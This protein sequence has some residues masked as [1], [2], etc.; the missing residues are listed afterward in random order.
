MTLRV[1]RRDCP[2]V[3]RSTAR[4]ERGGQRVVDR[5]RFDRVRLRPQD[6]VRKAGVGC[7]RH[8]VLGRVGDA[9][10][11]QH[12][13]FA[14]PPD[15][16]AVAAC[17]RRLRRPPLDDPSHTGP[18]ARAV[19]RRE[20]AHAPVVG[21]VRDVLFERR[22]GVVRVRRAAAGPAAEDDR[23]KA[24]VRGHL[25]FVRG[26]SSHR[27]PLDGGQLLHA[28]PVARAHRHRCAQAAGIRGARR[29]EQCETR[30]ND[31]PAHRCRRA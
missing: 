22:C 12:E 15:G 26:R 8:D 31:D 6:D 27:L 5:L 29:C 2:V 18:R 3:R 17:Q 14:W 16:H 25:V 30:E 1:E 11:A 20:R 24:G 21:P 28:R 19:L 13:R 10:P 9:A 23:V 4:I 7:D